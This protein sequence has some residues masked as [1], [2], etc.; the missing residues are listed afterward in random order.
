LFAAAII[1]RAEVPV[2][3]RRLLNVESGINDGLAL[4]AVTILLA[5]LEHVPV[6]VGA[7]VEQILLGIG[8]G[9]AVPL[10]LTAALNSRFFAAAG[11]YKRLGAISI[12]FSVFAFSSIT[13]ANEFLAAFAAGVTI[14]IA[15]SSM[16]RSFH[17]FGETIS[18][19]MKLAAILLFGAV[20]SP[21]FFQSFSWGAYLFVAAAILVARPAGLAPALAGTRLSG[22]ERAAILWFGPKGFASLLFGFLILN[23][24]IPDSEAMFKLIGLTVAIS[25]IAHS[26][27]DVTVARS[28]S[29]ISETPDS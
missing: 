12:G 28:F 15:N 20:L 3:V 13:H 17:E 22:R 21:E 5:Q 26:S 9:V 1:G 8:I 7:T 29:K 23:A 25:M 14:A 16:Q 4:P 6:G 18:E 19:L 10:A 2:R 11:V 24:P 27:T